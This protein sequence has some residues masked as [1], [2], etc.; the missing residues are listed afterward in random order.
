MSISVAICTFNGERYLQEQIESILNQ[1][2]AVE[3]IVICDDGSTDQTI[4]VAKKILDNRGFKNYHIIENK[5]RLGVTRNFEK[6][7]GSCTGDIVFICD[8]D[9]YWKPK[10]VE[11]MCEA[12][13]NED[14]LLAFCDAG[15]I[16]GEGAVVTESL[17]IKD[18]FA[19]RFGKIE[20]I[21]DSIIR[22]SYTIYGCTMGVK[23]DFIDAI[24]PFYD[25]PANHD[26][27]IMCCAILKGNIKYI[28]EPLMDY[29]I[30]GKN[31][32]GSIDGS[33]VWRKI[34]KEQNNYE[35][36]FAI[37]PLRELR[38]QLLNE[39]MQQM[40]IVNEGAFRMCQKAVRFWERIKRAESKNRLYRIYILM[41]SRLDSSY[42][43][44]FCDR[45]RSVTPQLIRKQFICDLLYML[46]ARC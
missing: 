28:N 23:K 44:R 3:E 24:F 1:T 16:D 25:S 42:K 12:L 46:R 22:L 9:D 27:W 37:Q 33:P 29:R 41:L 45:G 5:E 38:I 20:N 17:Y 15:V 4:S 21:Y 26:A 40:E 35:K 32:V 11:I 13:E 36:Y 34:V 43:Y 19:N 8:Q 2:V 31:T 18:G 39:A 7:I 14:C 6:C 10:K 30:H